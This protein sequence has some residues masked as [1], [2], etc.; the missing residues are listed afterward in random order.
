MSEEDNK[1]IIKICQNLYD[2]PRI[3]SPFDDESFNEAKKEVQFIK[4]LI[5][6]NNITE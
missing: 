6:Q 3:K 1:M 5:S 4:S 2:Y